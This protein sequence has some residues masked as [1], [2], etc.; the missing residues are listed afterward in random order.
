M[1]LQQPGQV[2]PS[3][4]IAEAPGKGRGLFAA[5]DLAEGEVI[6]TE[7]PLVGMQHLSNAESIETCAMC[8]RHVGELEAQVRNLMDS[9]AARQS[10]PL[11]MPCREEGFRPCPP[12]Y[13]CRGGCGVAF[14]GV[15]CEDRAWSEWHALLCAPRPDG[16]GAAM[17]DGG[18]TPALVDSACIAQLEAFRA[19]AIDTNEIFLL[20]ARVAAT[21]ALSFLS[22]GSWEAAWAPFADLHQPLWWEA[23]AFSAED[24]EADGEEAARAQMREVLAES[25][26]LLR[27]ALCTGQPPALQALP[28]FQSAELYAHI[29]GM[30]E[31]NNCSMLVA[32]PVED[33]FL[34][35]DALP[36]GPAKQA[37]EAVTAPVLDALG[38]RYALP[39][40]GA[41]VFWLQAVLNH[42]CVP[43]VGFVKRDEDVDGRVVLTAN[44]PI[45]AG[46]ELVHSYIDE[47]QPLDARTEELRNYGFVCDCQL[48]VDER[49]RAGSTSASHAHAGRR[50][51]KLK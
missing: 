6:F 18:S 37:I 31:R 47:G 21:A 48:C 5:R 27:V 9:D 35:I 44:R 23:V 33:Y 38:E 24:I 50:G 7:L 42:A 22:L 51:G 14:C 46:E 8:M 32:S 40:E 1:A 34:H 10:I 4:F 41:G 39:A 11:A 16:A 28:I 2:P 19:H 20:A 17:S 26:T 12:P 25:W 49:A 30:F 45:R 13:R 3:V 29:V 43:N 36:D 15:A